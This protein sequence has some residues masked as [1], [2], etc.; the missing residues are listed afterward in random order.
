MVLATGG[1]IVSE[2]VTFDLIL[3]SYYTIWLKAEPEEHMARVRKQGDLRPM[4]DDRSAMAEL[5]NILVSREPLYAR[6]NAVV[7]TAGL[8]VDA[9]AARL[10]DAVKPVLKDDAKMFARG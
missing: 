4:A 9:A 10:S 6:A 2:P 5:R 7:D 8:T 3:K 1:G